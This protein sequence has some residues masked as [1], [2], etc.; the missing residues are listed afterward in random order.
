MD[1]RLCIIYQILRPEF[2]QL[3]EVL[4]KFRLK[5]SETLIEFLSSFSELV[6]IFS[7]LPPIY[8]IPIFREYIH[9]NY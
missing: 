5:G 4:F 6:S 2:L 1:N 9:K 3:Q 7:R 8:E